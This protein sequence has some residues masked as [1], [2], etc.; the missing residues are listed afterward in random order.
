MIG[1]LI[2]LAQFALLLLFMSCNAISDVD[3]SWLIWMLLV[4]SVL[5]ICVPVIRGILDYIDNSP[6]TPWEN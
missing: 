4:L 3:N 5:Q 2:G 1:P 6:L